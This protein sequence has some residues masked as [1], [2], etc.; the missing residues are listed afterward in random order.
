MTHRQFPDVVRECAR[1]NRDRL[2]LATTAA[3]GAQDLSS[4]H[5]KRA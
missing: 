3:A 4:S 1:R 5:S 2:D